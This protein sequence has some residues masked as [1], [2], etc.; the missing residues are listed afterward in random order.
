MQSFRCPYQDHC[1]P[2]WW[3]IPPQMEVLT[4]VRL[5]APFSW[6]WRVVTRAVRSPPAAGAEPLIRSDSAP[7]AVLLVSTDLRANQPLIRGVNAPVAVLLSLSN[8]RATQ[9][10]IGGVR[11]PG[12][13]LLSLS[14]LRASQRLIRRDSASGAVLLALSDLRATRARSVD[15]ACVLNPPCEPLS[16]PASGT[17]RRPETAVGYC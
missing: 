7:I 11:A 17:A 10:L 9:P 13:V 1:G 16:L 8:L 4:E 6:F 2:Q 3:S 14:D 12:A 5:H 15:C